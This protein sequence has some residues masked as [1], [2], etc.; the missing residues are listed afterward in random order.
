MHVVTGSFE[1]FPGKDA[2]DWRTA[3]EFGDLAGPV[4]AP[5]V[6]AYPSGF[7]DD[8]CGH[9]M[10]QAYLPGMYGSSLNIEELSTVRGALRH[11]ASMVLEGE[12]P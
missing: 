4:W 3:D 10:P 11:F 12:Q 8:S 2:S 9:A 7:F 6:S 5:R 1:S